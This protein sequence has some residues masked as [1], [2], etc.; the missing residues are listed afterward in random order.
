M[1]NKLY[2]SFVAFALLLAGNLTKAQV[3]VVQSGANASV[4]S[5]LDDAIDAASPGDYLYLSGDLFLVHGHQTGSSDSMHFGKPLHFVGAGINADSTS[6]TRQTRIQSAPTSSNLDGHLTIGSAAGGSTFDGIIFSGS[7]VFFQNGLVIPDSSGHFSFNRCQMNQCNLGAVGGG[8][9]PGTL[10]VELHECILT[11]GL[12]NA[13]TG[14]SSAAIDRCI[15][16]SL[17]QS[18]SLKPSISKLV[19]LPC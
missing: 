19:E 4:Y 11:G 2:S 8:P 1:K 3:V 5:N 7:G 15:V 17:A 6:V 16:M 12:L 13:G 18:A 10:S 9:A 14:I